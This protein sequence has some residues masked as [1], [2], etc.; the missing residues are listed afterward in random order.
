MKAFS[1]NTAFSVVRATYLD[2]L[3]RSNARPPP[4]IEYYNNAKYLKMTNHLPP[5]S[6]SFCLTASH[7]GE[8]S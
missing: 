5:Y 1:V 7:S 4:A 3:G 6:G 2:W 8:R